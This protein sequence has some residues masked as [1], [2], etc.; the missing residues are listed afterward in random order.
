MGVSY[1]KRQYK[2]KLLDG[3]QIVQTEGKCCNLQRTSS[4]LQHTAISCALKD[5]THKGY[6][7]T[8]VKMYCII[9]YILYLTLSGQV[10]LLRPRSLLQ[11]RPVITKIDIKYNY[12]MQNCTNIKHEGIETQQQLTL[13]VSVSNGCHYIDKEHCG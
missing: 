1:G 13:Y 7:N 11:M 6:P 5:Q 10:V 8:Y 4:E 2:Q 9:S 12:K 3:V